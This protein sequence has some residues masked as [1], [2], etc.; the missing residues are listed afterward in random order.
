MEI[1]SEGSLAISRYPNIPNS[2]VPNK[3]IEHI[4][5]TISQF[6]QHCNHPKEF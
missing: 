5:F 4:H 3:K 6:S 1:S 2:H